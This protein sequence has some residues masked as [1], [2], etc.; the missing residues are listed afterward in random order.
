MI[1]K[2]KIMHFKLHFFIPLTFWACFLSINSFS[3]ENSSKGIEELAK[4]FN[5]PEQSAKP[6]VYWMWMNG[7]ISAE[8]ITNDLQAMHD[9]GIGGVMMFNI[10]M[11]PE[12]KIHY[13][14]KEWMDMVRHAAVT[15]HKLGIKFVFHNCDGWGSSGGPWVTKENAMKKIVYS[16]TKIAGGELY[17]QAV[18]LPKINLDYYKD[19]AILAFPTPAKDIRVPNI[20]GKA[21]NTRDFNLTIGKEIVSV[22]AMIKSTDILDLSK[23]FTDK[24]ILNWKAPAGKFWTILRTD[25][26]ALPRGARVHYSEASGTKPE[27]VWARVRLHG[28]LRRGGC[29]R[30]HGPGSID[31]EARPVKIPIQNG[32]PHAA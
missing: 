14:T 11:N 5:E 10:G 2:L 25:L 27:D 22:D 29:V 21:G 15:A 16:E 4:K 9:V 12:G 24:G 26:L 32:G 28:E 6:W 8:G 19:I 30:V 13:R 20:S 31:A 18:P 1:A 7:N 3:Q 17:N 23:Y